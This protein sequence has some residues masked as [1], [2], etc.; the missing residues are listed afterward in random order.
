MGEDGISVLDFTTM[1]LLTRYNYDSIVTFGGCQ[2]DFMMVVMGP[3][4]RTDSRMQFRLSGESSGTM[5]MLF[6]TKKPEVNY[7]L[8]KGN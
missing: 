7:Y 8:G 5:K 3:S 6:R 2:D 4:E 1:Q